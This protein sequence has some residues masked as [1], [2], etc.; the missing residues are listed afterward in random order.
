MTLY[1]LRVDDDEEKGINNR[2]G[3]VFVG[4]KCFRKLYVTVILRDWAQELAHVIEMTNV[5]CQPYLNT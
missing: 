5:R 4:A 2:A 1:N 3:K